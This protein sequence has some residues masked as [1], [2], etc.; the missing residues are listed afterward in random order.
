MDYTRIFMLIIPAYL[1]TIVIEWVSWRRS[2]G[3]DRKRGFYRPDTWNSVVIGIAS[4]ITRSLENLLVPFSFVLVG[5]VLTPIQ[6]P[7]DR[8]WTWGIGLIAT[9]FCYYWGHRA[10]HRVRIL[11][12]AH[13]VHHSS[14][15]FNLTTGIRM[16]FLMPYATFLHNA[17]F[18]PVALIG[19]PPYII[20]F[21]QFAS[22]IY[23]WPIHTQRIGF[24][25]APIEYIFNTPSHH[26]VHHGADNPYLD[27]NYGAVLI[28]WDRIFGTYA[29][30]S[31]PVTYGLTKNVGT[32]N[33]IKTNYH[34]FMAM[35]ADIGQARG[36]RPTLR[37]LFG[38][39]TARVDSIA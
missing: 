16:P 32:F 15:Q 33:P 8:W 38:P 10:D 19:V 9:D 20:F 2:A 23:Q 22:S 3:G 13:S 27:K 5:A 12:S 7:A 1:F 37:A 28:I 36:A 34:E 24:L 25:P 17:A 6:L 35:L 4:R 26:R 30:E 31:T 11:W 18:M 29:H 21:W 39:P 14:E